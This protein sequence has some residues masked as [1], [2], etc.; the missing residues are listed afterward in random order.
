LQKEEKEEVGMRRTIATGGIALVVSTVALIAAPVAGATTF[1][2]DTPITISAASGPANPYPSSITVSGTAGPITDVNVGLDELTHTSPYDLSIVLQ[3]PSGEALAIQ[4]CAGNLA[5]TAGAFLTF[6]DA[7]GNDLPE[8]G[9][10]VTGTFR[11]TSHCPGNP[12]LPAPGPLTNYGNPGPGNAGTATFATAFNGRSAIGTWNLFVF[13]RFGG[14]AGSIPGGW[15]LDVKPDISPLATTPAQT[16]RPLIP[17]AK[18][19]TTCKKKKKK[20]KGARAAACKNKK[21]K[22]RR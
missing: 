2:N 15:S 16:I 3:A 4:N 22:K 10:L 13:D 19:T 8:N 11:P 14:D 1:N 7:A 9:P 5:A 20:K 18:P 12:S 6:D 21:K 17:T